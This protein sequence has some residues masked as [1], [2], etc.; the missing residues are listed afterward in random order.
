MVQFLLHV[1]LGMFIVITERKLEF[2]WTLLS[3]KW[4][5]VWLGGFATNTTAVHCLRLQRVRVKYCSM[6]VKILLLWWGLLICIGFSNYRL[7]FCVGRKVE[8]HSTFPPK[9][10]L[11]KHVLTVR[12]LGCDSCKLFFGPEY[13]SIRNILFLLFYFLLCQMIQDGSDSQ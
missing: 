6:F 5:L 1:K 7:T 9:L 12:C 4:L 2:L 13:T 11:L 3:G 10:H 8:G